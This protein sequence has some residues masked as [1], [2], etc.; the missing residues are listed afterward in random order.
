MAARLSSTEPWPALRTGR[1]TQPVGLRPP[2]GPPSRSPLQ[3]WDLRLGVRGHRVRAWPWDIR[4][5]AGHA[6]WHVGFITPKSIEVM[7]ICE[8]YYYCPVQIVCAMAQYLKVYFNVHCDHCIILCEF[9]KWIGG[10]KAQP[11][12]FRVM[13]TIKGQELLMREEG[14]ICG[15]KCR[16]HKVGVGG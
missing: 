14:V 12:R 1:W 9:S 5:S 15:Q 2:E 4:I 16:T 11:S 6:E 8:S 13:V 10:Q 3:L 7:L